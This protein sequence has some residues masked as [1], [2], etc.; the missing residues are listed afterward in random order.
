MGTLHSP[1][2]NDDYPIKIPAAW[3]IFKD[4]ESRQWTNDKK[5]YPLELETEDISGDEDRK[6]RDDFLTC[7]LIGN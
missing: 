5:S 4:E 2:I 1:C 7:N 3:T 6:K